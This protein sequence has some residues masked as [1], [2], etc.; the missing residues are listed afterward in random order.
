M[1]MYARPS[2]DP[3]SCTDNDAGVVQRGGR[4]GLLLRNAAT[5]DPARIPPAGPSPRR[6][7]AE[8]RIARSIRPRPCR[9]RRA[10]A[11]SRTIRSSFREKGHRCWDSSGRASLAEV[12]TL[13]RLHGGGT[14]RITLILRFP[15]SSPDTGGRAESHGRETSSTASSRSSC[16]PRRRSPAGGARTRAARSAQSISE[17]ST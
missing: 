17:R 10:E 2:A 11:R 13:R 6:V 1:A 5:L 3:M 15:E 9:R 14:E 7:A 12:E 8:S 4:P 16:T